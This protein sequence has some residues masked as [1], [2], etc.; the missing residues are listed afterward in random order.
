MWNYRVVHRS[1]PDW[2]EETYSICECYYDDDGK[3]EAI[4]ERSVGAFGGTLEELLADL[5]NY[6]NA[7]HK[8]V[9]QWDEIVRDE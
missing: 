4:T 8:P 3:P 2:D 5:E 7:V 6:R 1:Y 9:L